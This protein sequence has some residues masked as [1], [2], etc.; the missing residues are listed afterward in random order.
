M[1]FLILAILLFS[2]N[3]VLWKSFLSKTSVLFLATYRSFVTSTIAL[4]LLFIFY[5]VFPLD[6]SSILRISLGSLFGAIG[7]YSMLTIIQKK[8]LQWVAV[9]NLIGVCFTAFYLWLFENINISAAITGLSIIILGFV[10]YSYSNSASKI[11]ISI[12]QHFI[13]LLMTCSFNLSGIL[14]WK[15][16]A[17]EIP[18]ILIIANQELI[19]FSIGFL[20]LLK[21][22]EIKR[23]QANIGPYFKKIVLMSLIVFIALFF[24][25]MGLK[26]TNPLISSV[27][28]LASPLTTI[29][30]SALFFKE[31]I[32]LINWIAILVIAVG[33]LVVHWQTL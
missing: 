24:S 1:A 12:P 23:V 33:A 20:L 13:L 17:K 3:N 14:H 30:F 32:T 2:F 26:D 21:R 4:C 6:Y 10:F 22:K 16:L 25:F 5:N 31:R 29:V 8:S 11:A 18:P 28:F 7:L 9:Y 19:V 15:N 27:L